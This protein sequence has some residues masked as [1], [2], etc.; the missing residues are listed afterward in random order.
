ML[1]NENE[2]SPTNVSI[3]TQHTGIFFLE[4]KKGVMLCIFCKVDV[5]LPVGDVKQ[6]HL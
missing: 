6:E 5:F 1:H 3:T 4:Q 2:K